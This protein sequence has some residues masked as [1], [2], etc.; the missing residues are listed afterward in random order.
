MADSAIHGDGYRLLLI[1]PIPV[2]GAAAGLLVNRKEGDAVA[3]EVV[4]EVGPKRRL[5]L[6]ICEI[7]LDDGADRGDLRPCDGN[8]VT[9][10]WR[11]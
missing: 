7:G 4:E 2:D 3:G 8:A 10:W 11:R 1:E 9:R 5:N 6:E